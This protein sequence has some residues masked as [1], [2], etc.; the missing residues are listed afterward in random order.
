[1]GARLTLQ[2]RRERK[3]GKGGS[4]WSRK[5]KMMVYLGLVAAMRKSVYPNRRLRRVRAAG[6]VETTGIDCV[7]VVIILP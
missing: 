2:C 7:I 4:R 3:T 5:P 6:V 1:M